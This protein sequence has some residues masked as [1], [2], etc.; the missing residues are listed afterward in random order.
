[1]QAVRASRHKVKPGHER[2]NAE[3]VFLPSILGPLG[4]VDLA[5]YYPTARC[6]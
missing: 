4:G 2:V 5:A 3:T 1:M 6:R